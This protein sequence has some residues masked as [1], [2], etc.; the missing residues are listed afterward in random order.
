MIF[1]IS[2]FS[3]SVSCAAV[4][5]PFS[6]LARASLSGAVRKMLPTTSARNGGFVLVIGVLLRIHRDQQAGRARFVNDKTQRAGAADGLRPN[7]LRRTIEVI[8]QGKAR[9]DRSLL[10]AAATGE[11]STSAATDHTSMVTLPPTTITG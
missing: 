1:S 4:I 10:D 6:R 2:R 9:P 11:E 5:S 7:R 3:T 8:A